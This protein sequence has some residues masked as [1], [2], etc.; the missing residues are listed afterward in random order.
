M[1]AHTMRTSAVAVAM[2]VVLVAGAH[3]RA[4]ESDAGIPQPA[5]LDMAKA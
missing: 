5:A 3:T 2:A 4:A 1:W